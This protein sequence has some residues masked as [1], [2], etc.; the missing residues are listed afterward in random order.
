MQK[1]ALALAF[2]AF[3]VAAQASSDKA[4]AAILSADDVAAGVLCKV[5]DVTVLAATADDCGKIGGEATHKVTTV[6]TPIK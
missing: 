6:K 1:V 4:I 2:L 5:K 3:P